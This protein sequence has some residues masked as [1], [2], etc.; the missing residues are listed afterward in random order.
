MSTTL[1]QLV[2]RIEPD[3]TLDYIA[4]GVR[5]C[6]KDFV[7]LKDI[8]TE[9]EMKDSTACYMDKSDCN[10]CWNRTLE[11]INQDLTL[12]DV[13]KIVDHRRID[14]SIFG[15]V[16]GCP[17]DKI[18]YDYGRINTE[19][20]VKTNSKNCKEC[21][22][23]KLIDLVEPTTEE[24]KQNKICEDKINKELNDVIE[25]IK[26]KKIDIHKKVSHYNCGDIECI[27]AI[28]EATKSLNGV[29]A[30]I[31]GNIIKYAWRWKEKGVEK[32]LEKIIN[33]SKMLIEYIQ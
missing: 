21:W 28:A 12:K 31:T 7:F 1:K 25:Q 22:N 6:P 14:D 24:K 3:K 29:E 16:Q 18:I 27:D 23:T 9:E 13:M 2:E 20:C 32:D 17:V 8:L 33:Y 4:G 15:G 19:K 26:N 10:K 5:G 30:F 11:E